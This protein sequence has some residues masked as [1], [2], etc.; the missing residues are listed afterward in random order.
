M[1]INPKTL[2]PRSAEDL[3]KPPT[4][5]MYKAL[6]EAYEEYLDYVVQQAFGGDWQEAMDQSMLALAVESNLA[7]MQRVS[8]EP[9]LRITEEKAF[10]NELHFATVCIAAMR[11]FHAPPDIQQRA[12][13]VILNAAKEV[14]AE[15]RA[16]STNV[17]HA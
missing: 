2:F 6:K 15:K 8:G 4:P 9:P 11:G 5:E 16:V 10:S 14:N 7:A 13:K 12:E 1:S 17:S 3:V